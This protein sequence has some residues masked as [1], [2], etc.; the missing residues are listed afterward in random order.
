MVVVRVS[1]P[2]SEV[3]H[4]ARQ[5]PFLNEDIDSAITGREAL[6]DYGF[7]SCPSCSRANGSPVT[8]SRRRFR[9]IAPS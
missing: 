6:A 4:N 5:P 2:L 8:C 1:T 9:V 3:A 7:R